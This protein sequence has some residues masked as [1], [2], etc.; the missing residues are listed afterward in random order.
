V[1]R[2]IGFPWNK[3]ASV[4]V[5]VSAFESTGIYRLNLNRGPECFFSTSDT[6]ETVTF[7]ETAH[8]LHQEQTPKMCYL[9]QQDN[10]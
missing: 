9:F 1:E 3:A 8:T 6:S 5:D 2:L 7:M 4:G 10:H